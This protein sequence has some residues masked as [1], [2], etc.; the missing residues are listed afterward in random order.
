V[1][2]PEVIDLPDPWPACRTARCG[3]SVAVAR[4]D[5]PYGPVVVTCENG[6]YRTYQK[7]GDFRGRGRYARLFSEAAVGALPPRTA[8]ER[9]LEP[10]ERRC[11]E[12]VEDAERC[13]LCGTPP[14]EHPFRP[15][16]DLRSDRDVWAWFQRWRPQVYAE[17]REAVTIVQQREQVTFAGW[18]L[19][20]PVALRERVV[21]ALEE[22]ALQ[23]D[24][25]VPFARLAPVLDALTAR[26]LDF[27][28]HQL[29]VAICRRCNDG[30]WRTAL[31]REDYLREYVR[32]VHGGDERMA[33][34]DTERWQLME[35]VALAAARARLVTDERSA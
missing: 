35:S 26:E 16:L 25:V 3:S 34:A 32:A 33:R 7:K 24:H 8:R 20:I 1:F 27:A 9:R 12:I 31:V 2:A 5:A 23:A 19:K 10:N 22:S 6:H 30:R 28:V 21:E 14:A 29:L 17:L 4:I 13:A 11:A 18:R 15:D